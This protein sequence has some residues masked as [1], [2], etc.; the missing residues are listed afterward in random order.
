MIAKREATRSWQDGGVDCKYQMKSAVVSSRAL[1]CCTHSDSECQSANTCVLRKL[2][3]ALR[4]ISRAVLPW[5][6]GVENAVTS[7]CMTWT[8]VWRKG[9]YLQ[10]SE[11]EQPAKVLQTPPSD[12]IREM[13]L[14][15]RASDA[16]LRRPG[17]SVHYF[18]VGAERLVCG[19]VENILST[20]VEPQALA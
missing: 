8:R 19:R 16:L 10:S 14:L 12:V 1:L 7:I 18:A 5:Q 2:R 13:P 3:E 6:M 17:S 11:S 20:S 9:L 4:V 15:R